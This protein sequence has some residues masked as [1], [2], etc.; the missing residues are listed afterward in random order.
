MR[1]RWTLCLFACVIVLSCTS[2]RAESK[3]ALVC[4]TTQNP[5]YIIQLVINFDD[6][7]VTSG[8]TTYDAEFTDTDISWTQRGGEYVL[9]RSTLILQIQWH[10]GFSGPNTYECKVT[11]GI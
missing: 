7:T 3:K 5:D 10:R 9:T 8:S 1:N 2:L 11:E 4:K 6:K